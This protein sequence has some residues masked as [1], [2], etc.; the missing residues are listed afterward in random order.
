VFVGKVIM[1]TGSFDHHHHHAGV[2]CFSAFSGGSGGRL[3]VCRSPMHD[4][5]VVV[6][7]WQHSQEKER[8]LSELTI[9]DSKL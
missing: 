8:N 2:P 7:A 3:G 9:S 4:F 1:N 5:S 6:K